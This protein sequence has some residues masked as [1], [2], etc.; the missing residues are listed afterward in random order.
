MKGNVSLTPRSLRP[1]E[2]QLFVSGMCR[3]TKTEQH[4]LA[5][6]PQAVSGRI[7]MFCADGQKA[8]AMVL[9]GRGG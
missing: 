2:G 8:R 9:E 7:V 4:I 5:P 6:P 3:H 1:S